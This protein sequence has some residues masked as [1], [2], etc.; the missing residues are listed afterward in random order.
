[1]LEGRTLREA[2]PTLAD[3]LEPMYRAALAGR[4]S[5]YD[6]EFG[7][8]TFASRTVPVRDDDDVVVAGMVMAVDVTEARRSE[9]LILRL[10]QDLERGVAELT[11][12][13]Q[14]LEAFSY[15]VSHDLRA[16]LRHISGFVDLLRR[17]SEERLDEKGRRQLDTIS[18]A[19]RTMGELID[20]LLAFSR[21]SRTR[22]RREPVDL[23]FLVREVVQPIRLENAGRAVEWVI[24]DLPRVLADPSLLRIVL[25]NLVGNAVKYTR[26]RDPAR[27][28]IGSLA[29]GD[30]AG[31][32]PPAP[33][34]DTVLFVRDNGVGFDMEYAGKLFGVFQRLHRADEFEGTGIGLATV[35]RIVHRHGG[36]TWA[37]GEADRG[38]TFY[39]SLP[40]ADGEA[41]PEAETGE[42]RSER[43]GELG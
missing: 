19:A 24:G 17:G 2:L 21:T 4:E 38:A 1:M 15:S 16:P 5:A 31:Q 35:R 33:W 8:R 20:D 6:V 37:M 18:R 42:A 26:G 34:P 3:R 11:T 40:L 12:A 29:A 32:R 28:E 14:E 39:F 23:A 30:P 9:A 27:I 7:G 22:L 10:N 43:S 36:R 41:A 13:N 25:T